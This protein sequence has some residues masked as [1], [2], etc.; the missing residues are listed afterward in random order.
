MTTETPGPLARARAT[1][2]P[3]AEPDLVPD[4]LAGRRATTL[5]AY[6]AA[7][8]SFR[9]FLGA[10]D[11][12]AAARALL[13]HGPGPANLLVH[14]YRASLVDQGLA[15]AT[16]NLRLTALRSLVGFAQ[17]I[18]RVEWTVAVA[19]VR[20]QAYRDTRGPGRGAVR[21]ILRETAGGSTPMEL[22][23]RAILRLLVDLAL[24]RGEVVSLDLEHADLGSGRVWVLGKGAGTGERV[25]LTLPAPTSE[26]LA[27]WIAVRGAEPG[28]L[29]ASCLR[30][31][32]LRRGRD[33]ALSRISG[34]DVHRLVG[35]VSEAAGVGRVRPHALRHAAV[36]AALDATGGD[37]RRVQRFSR[38]ASVEVLLRYDDARADDAGDVARLVAAQ[39]GG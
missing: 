31:G 18:G 29:F 39:V 12:A 10:A 17:L 8:E 37:V 28:P 16:V 3:A 21:R 35:R 36:T 32:S 11:I 22:R 9:V 13:A 23:N 25:A 20:S 5:R 26:A 19:N 1:E 30:G 7:L 6:R 34:S 24:R 15:P 27:A 33:G 4:F 38:H 14:R 2:P